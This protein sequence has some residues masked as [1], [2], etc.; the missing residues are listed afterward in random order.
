MNN[1]RKAGALVLR[2]LFFGL[3]LGWRAFAADDCC[4]TQCDQQDNP[5]TG[6]LTASQEEGKLMLL[7][8]TLSSEDT[9]PESFF[10]AAPEIWDELKRAFCYFEVS[11]DRPSGAV[12][13]M[14]ES[15]DISIE[16]LPALVVVL[17]DGS[18]CGMP[19]VYITAKELSTLT[20]EDLN[21]LAAELAFFTKEELSL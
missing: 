10:D 18:C 9:S 21:L 12:Q 6:A 20:V 2:V 15:C 8:I 11:A 14:L 13:W 1:T 7:G 16:D 4:P 3:L 5:L 17:P 19:L